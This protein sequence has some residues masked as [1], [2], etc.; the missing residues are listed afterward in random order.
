MEVGD[1]LEG[2]QELSAWTHGE[3]CHE[4]RMSEGGITTTG[5]G[6]ED[7]LHPSAKGEGDH[8]N[9]ILHRVVDI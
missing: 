6:T 3:E 8:S 5:L 1:G 7:A 4:S 2:D 9:T